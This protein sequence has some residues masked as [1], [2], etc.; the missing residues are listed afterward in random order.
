MLFNSPQFIFGFLPV[1]LLGFFIL[2]RSG[3]RG[4][5]ILWLGLVSLVFYGFDN[6]ALQLPLI[7]VSITFNFIV[8]RRLA[9][10]RSRNVL[11]LGAGGNLLLLGFFKYAGLLIGTVNGLSGFAL[12]NPEIPLPIGISFYT[13]TQIAFLVDVYRSEAREYGYAKYGL[14]VTFFPHLIAGPILHHKE[15]VPQFDRPEVSGRRRTAS[16]S[17]RVIS[18]S[19]C[20]RR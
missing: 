19:A 10:A 12:P 1:A 20:S 7:L 2:G 16:R 4:L 15:T 18:P 11:I 9:H 13:F 6:P 14:F 8:G 17:V 3:F 5:A